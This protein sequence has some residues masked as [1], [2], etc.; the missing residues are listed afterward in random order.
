MMNYIW[1]EVTSTKFLLQH[2]R[3]SLP[4]P[5]PSQQKSAEGRLISER[6][7]SEIQYINNHPAN[8]SN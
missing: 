1:W 2:S 8:L 4:P 6:F 3:I 5:Q 7:N